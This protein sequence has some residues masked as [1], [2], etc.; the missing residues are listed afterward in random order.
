M[1]CNRELRGH[2]DPTSRYFQNPLLLRSHMQLLLW[3]TRPAIM[4]YLSTFSYSRITY[5]LKTILISLYALNATAI[6]IIIR[7]TVPN[8]AN[9]RCVHSAR[10]PIIL[11]SSA[12]SRRNNASTAVVHIAP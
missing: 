10:V 1:I 12:H 9:I 8:P 6:M 4:V 7:L 11:I 5:L 2:H 3:Q